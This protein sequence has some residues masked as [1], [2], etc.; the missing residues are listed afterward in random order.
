MVLFSLMGMFC[1]NKKGSFDHV[2]T[3]PQ[4]HFVASLGSAQDDN[5]MKTIKS[6]S[7]EMIRRVFEMTG[8]NFE[9]T[10]I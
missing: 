6:T 1:L 5:I 7:L 2:N 4:G 10:K 3:S 8:D 9:M